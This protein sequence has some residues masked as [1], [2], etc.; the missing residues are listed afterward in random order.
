MPVARSKA[1]LFDFTVDADKALEQHRRTVFHLRRIDTRTFARLRDLSDYEGKV[2]EVTIRAGVEGW[3]NFCE[4][5]GTKVEAKKDRGIHLI[6]GL[7]IAEPLS[8][9]SM[10]RIPPEF[11]GE[12]SAAVITGSTITP[13]DAK[14]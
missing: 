10:N 6:H 8:L 1:D 5:D 11:L 3:S 14:N 9:E 4:A 12:I 7:E 13:A 2:C